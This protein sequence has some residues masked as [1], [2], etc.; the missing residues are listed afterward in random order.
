MADIEVTVIIERFGNYKK[1]DKVTMNES[2]A[3]ACESKK[4]VSTGIKAEKKVESKGKTGNT[5][6]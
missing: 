3:I 2:T 5:E 6:D 4:V 1:G